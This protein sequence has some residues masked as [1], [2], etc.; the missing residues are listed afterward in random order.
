MAATP[1]ISLDALAGAIPVREPVRLS[2]A[3]REWLASMQEKEAGSS[4][5]V[6]Y[7]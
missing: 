4:P 5:W 1:D 6:A 3:I 2:D 7:R